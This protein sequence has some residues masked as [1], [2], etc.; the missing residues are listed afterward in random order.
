MTVSDRNKAV[1]TIEQV[2]LSVKKYFGTATENRLKIRPP[3]QDM[4]F[5]FFWFKTQNALHD[6]QILYVDSFS[7][8]SERLKF[9]LT[10]ARAI[11]HSC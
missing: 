3:A 1:T 7:L 9:M 11:V 10:V 8:T 2:Q 4:N 5:N 6:N